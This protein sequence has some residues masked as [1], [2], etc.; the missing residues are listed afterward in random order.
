MNFLKKKENILTKKFLKNG[1][2]IKKVESIKSLK[3]L[4]SVIQDSLKKN[5]NI[6]KDIN[7]NYIH[8]YIP[9]ADLNEFRVKL[10]Y[11]LNNNESAK[12]N[13]FNIAREH[14]YTIAGNELMMQR[15]INLSIQFPEDES[16]LLPVHSDV[17]SGDSPYE[18]NLWIPLVNCYKTKS[19][20]LLHQK[21]FSIF[22]KKIAYLKNISS[23]KI[24]KKIS[25]D[26]NWIKINYGEFL[27]FNQS[28]PHG[29]IVNR[30]KQTRWSLN[31]RFKNIF[32]PY[33]DKK[34]G[35]FFIPI[36]TRATTNIG[37]NYKSPF[38]KI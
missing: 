22:K 38:E 5:L 11:D 16:S 9:L 24:Y 6:K 25:N 29:N 10:I 37:I 33:A 34:I 28:L 14:L 36:T 32:S 18:I 3:F 35:E 27:L 12:L 21:K 15:N 31:C 30:E 19:M 8:K 26:V 1:F 17:W 20:Y 7:L 2:I 13:Y 23:S 4:E